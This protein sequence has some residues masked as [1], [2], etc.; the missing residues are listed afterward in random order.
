MGGV[1]DK[2]R[3]NGEGSTRLVVRGMVV[4]GGVEIKNE[5]GSGDKGVRVSVR[6]GVRQRDDK[7]RATVIE[8]E[9]VAGAAAAPPARPTT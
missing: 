8:D 7:S 6:A 5:R 4:M 1:E 2:T 9:S 3:W